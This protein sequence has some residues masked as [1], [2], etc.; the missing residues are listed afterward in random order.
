MGAEWG[1][2]G[3]GRLQRL[4]LSLHSSEKKKELLVLIRMEMIPFHHR[5]ENK[6]T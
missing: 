3:V 6:T 5:L 4:F 2:V 1:E